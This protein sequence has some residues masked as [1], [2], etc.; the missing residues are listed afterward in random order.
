MLIL[1]LE[2]VI[3]IGELALCYKNVENSSPS[4]PEIAIHDHRLDETANNQVGPK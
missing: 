2:V 1:K 3:T 4:S